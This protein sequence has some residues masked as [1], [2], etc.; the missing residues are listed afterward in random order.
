LQMHA[1]TPG[2]LGFQLKPLCVHRKYFIH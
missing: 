1:T 2:F